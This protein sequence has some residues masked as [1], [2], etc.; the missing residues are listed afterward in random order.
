MEK[1]E[2]ITTGRELIVRKN[3]NRFSFSNSRNYSS[4]ATYF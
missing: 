4:D 3:S 1:Y 2:E